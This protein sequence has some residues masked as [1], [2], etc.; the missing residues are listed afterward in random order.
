MCHMWLALPEHYPAVHLDLWVLMPN[1]LHGIVWLRAIPGT[2][3]PDLGTVI[4]GFKSLTTRSYITG[5]HDL[6]WEPFD[7]QLWQRNYYE[8]IVRNEDDLNRIRDYIQ[9]NPVRW[10]DDP[11]R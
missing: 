6:G 9:A 11:L 8:H 3:T 7:Q 4:G 5:V 2:P 10:M 1:H